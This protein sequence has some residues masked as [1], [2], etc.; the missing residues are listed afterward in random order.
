MIVEVAHHAATS[1]P[2]EHVVRRRYRR[3]RAAVDL[4][5][6]ET[7]S[8]DDIRSHARAVGAADRNPDDEVTHQV[9]DGVVAEVALGP[10]EARA[11]AEVRFAADDPGTHSTSA[12]AERGLSVL[13][14]AAE[15]RSDPRCDEPIRARLHR[16][17]NHGNRSGKNESLD[18][19]LHDHVA[20][21]A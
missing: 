19:T 11:P 9:H 17:E 6:D 20:P 21:S 7:E 13:D 3:D 10:E 16:R 14:A 5:T 15:R 12:H 2:A 8:T 18:D 4:G 1:V